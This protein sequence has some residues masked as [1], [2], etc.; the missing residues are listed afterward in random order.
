MWLDEGQGTRGVAN[1][2]PIG[3]MI[4]GGGRLRC[5]REI[6]TDRSD[7]RC[8]GIC[9]ARGYVS[10]ARRLRG[11]NWTGSNLH[12]KERSAR[13]IQAINKTDVSAIGFATRE[14]TPIPTG[15]HELNIS[16]VPPL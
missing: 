7:Q 15:R 2:V 8:N 11:N 9:N 10:G 5:K 12:T 14:L 16:I 1:G 13:L 4:Y 3:L 6:K